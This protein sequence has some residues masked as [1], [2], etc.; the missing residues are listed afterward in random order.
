MIKKSF[1]FLLILPSL[2]GSIESLNS[3]VEMWEFQDQQQMEQ[4]LFQWKQDNPVTP[5]AFETGLPHP[6]DDGSVTENDNEEE[7]EIFD[8]IDTSSE[9]TGAISSNGDQ[10]NDVPTLITIRNKLEEL[11]KAVRG[12]RI[13]IDDNE[14]NA[15]GYTTL[16]DLHIELQ[17]IRNQHKDHNTTEI[18][19]ILDSVD[20]SVS[21]QEEIIDEEYTE[22]QDK[23]ANSE[24]T[25]ST[26]QGQNSYYIDIPEVLQ[27]YAKRS[28]IDLFNADGQL[29][30]PKLS[31][32]AKW[33]SLVIGLVAVFIYSQALKKL[34]DRVLDLLVT[35]N[36]S[37]TVTNYSV[38]GNS[39]GAVGIKALKSG[40]MIAFVVT[41]FLAMAAVLVESLSVNIGGTP[42]TG[43][44]DLIITQLSNKLSS[45]GV[46]S[47]VTMHWFFK[48]VPIISILYMVFQY[49]LAS[50][51]LKGILFAKNRALR[52]AS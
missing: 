22:F 10:D 47:Q 5:P 26:F 50:F 52:I 12:D 15:S 45:F 1:L 4:F 25:A 33:C 21:E 8:Q 27:P 51:G 16:S 29:P 36:E 48:F 37:N 2:F 14:S 24:I 44:S 28:N 34:L 11:N 7:N 18:D 46:W 40:L 42:Y 23:L 6:I 38:F 32:L 39:I 13:D 43:A 41:I 35:A 49:W 30:F 3:D 31:D 17:K 9:S 19:D 20:E